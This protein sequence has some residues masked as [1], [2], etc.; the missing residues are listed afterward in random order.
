MK[1]LL[2]GAVTA[3]LPLCL[4]AQTPVW[5]TDVAP[6]IYNNCT[7]CHHAG[8]IAPFTL[9]GYDSVA[10]RAGSIKADVLSGK[11]P[12][13]PPDP[14]YSRLAHQRILSTSQI[15][16]IVNWVNGGKPTGDMS[17]QPPTPVYSAHGMIPG[18]PDLVCK[19]PTYTSTADSNDV[20][21]C[22]VV[23][24]GLLT[25]K[26]IKAFEAV[27]G[28]PACVHHV[29]VFA[30]T[31][32]TCAGLDA[33]YPG[34]GYPNFGGVGSS[35]ATMVGVWVPGS[36]PM[37]YPSGFGLKLPRN[38]D[39][40]LQVHYPAGS[41]GLTD[42]TEV[43]FYFAPSAG[44]REVYME[45]LLYHESNL[46]GGPLHI[47][48]NTVKSYAEEVPGAQVFTDISMLGAFPHMHLLGQSI[49]SYGVSP[50][51]DTT[52]F[53]SINKWDFHWQ[54]FYMFPKI[55]KIQAGSKLRAEAIYD[56]TSANPENPHTPPQDVNAGEAT[57][58]EMMIVF[59]VF[60]FYQPGDEN[61]IADSAL[62]GTPAV[63]Q[64]YYRGEQILDVSPNPASVDMVVKCYMENPE[65]GDMAL[66]DMNGK[67]VRRFMNNTPM[68]GGYTAYTYS[69]AGV[70]N[71][72]Y[73]LLLKTN[74]QILSKKV[75]VNH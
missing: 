7:P 59:F 33:A 64:N 9:I 68:N 4:S 52:K 74:Q 11:M 26:Y 31:T 24:S 40:V 30:D 73:T 66:I 67:V 3:L 57:T 27:P 60:T 36:D 20:Y 39:V 35:N 47:P 46:I 37:S 2:L 72:T 15:N 32:G 21:Q 43:H 34:P 14:N 65:N 71:G 29:L 55:K 54:G 25:D 17:L 1:K 41:A 12:P 22:F 45:P 48:A 6:L 44:I 13:W 18:V 75:I 56:N 8:G 16:T 10:A 70:P 63:P 5:S 69:V 23:P 42:S 49:K 53:V 19:I 50:T 51:G 28:N 38:A 58:N 62:L 61:I